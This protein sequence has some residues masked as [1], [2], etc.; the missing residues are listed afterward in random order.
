MSLLQ[1][2]LYSLK[3]CSISNISCILLKKSGKLSTVAIEPV[4]RTIISPHPPGQKPNEYSQTDRGS[5]ASIFPKHLVR[6][7]AELVE[8]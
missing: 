1:L 6:C 8:S 4:N 3:K 7:V 2:T 5:R